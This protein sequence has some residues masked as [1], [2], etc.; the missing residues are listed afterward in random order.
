MRSCAAIWNTL[1]ADVYTMGAPVRMCSGPRAS[2]ISVPDATTLPMEVRPIRRS[3]SAMIS[4]E[5]PW[6]NVGN[7]RSSTMPI[8]S[9]WPVT[10]SLPGDASAIRPAAPIGAGALPPMRATR[11]NPSALRV[12][13]R[14]GTASAICPSVSLP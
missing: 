7:G 1:S 12:G 5:N 11:P 8:S 3:N 10:E 6:G 2:M 13:T 4:L 9:Q 14:R